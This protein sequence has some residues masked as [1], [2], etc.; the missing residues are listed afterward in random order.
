MKRRKKHPTLTINFLPVQVQTQMLAN[1]SEYFDSKDFYEFVQK[2]YH[3]K[4]FQ[5]FLPDMGNGL[6]DFLEQLGRTAGSI[7]NALIILTNKSNE[8][9][10]RDIKVKFEQPMPKG[11]N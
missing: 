3:T 10:H 4:K 9:I 8:S 11:V 5:K 1:L 2:N 6:V 7:R